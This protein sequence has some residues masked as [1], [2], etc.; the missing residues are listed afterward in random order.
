MNLSDFVF[1]IFSAVVFGFF[2]GLERQLTG[3]IAGIRTNVLVSL[4]ASIFVLFSIIVEAPDITRIAAQIVSGIGFLCSGIIFKEGTN[5]RGVNTAATIWCTA[6]I[7]VLCSAGK[8]LYALSATVVVLMG[9]L[10]F[11]FI[12]N[13]IYPLTGFHDGEHTYKITVICS[14]QKEFAVRSLIMTH[15]AGTRLTLIN[16][17]SADVIGGKVEIKATMLCENRRQNE[18]AEKLVG[19]IG[20]E[21]GVTKAGWELM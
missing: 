12:T 2:I 18:T 1:R 19:K 5:V 16:L 10:I 3:H 9:N 15:I 11:P 6:A 17:E 8:P 20:L 14:E 7:G 13:R 4:G 21:E